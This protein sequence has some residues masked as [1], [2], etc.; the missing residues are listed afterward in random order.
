MSSEKKSEDIDSLLDLLSNPLT[1]YILSVL[2]GV[3]PGSFTGT[4]EIGKKDKRTS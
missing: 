4:I 2:A 1:R 3:D